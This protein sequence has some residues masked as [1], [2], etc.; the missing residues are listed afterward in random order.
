MLINT[1]PTHKPLETQEKENSKRRINH[2]VK[3]LIFKC[4]S[5]LPHKI[6][7]ILYH[8]IQNVK[9]PAHNFLK[10][11]KTLKSMLKVLDKVGFDLNGKKVMELGSGWAP[12]LPYYFLSHF[13]LKSLHTIDINAHYQSKK[14]EALRDFF[15]QR[16]A[17]KGNHFSS[18]DGLV[19]HE[20][21]NYFPN[22]NL[23]QQRLRRNIDFGYSRFVLEHVPPQDILDIHL[24]MVKDMS[25]NSLILHF[26]SPSDHRSYSDNTLSLHDFLQYSDQEW[27]NIQTRFDYHNRLRFPQYIEI[28][29]KAGL[30]IVEQS[31]SLPKDKGELAKFNKLKIH[32]QFSNFTKDELTA[33]SLM[34]LL[35]KK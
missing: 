23:A 7:D 3:T 33:G 21:I 5:K 35:R 2:K 11:K 13:E 10:E 9:S 18:K 16:Q 28:F 30:E 34:F 19:M 31:H 32:K 17:L 14:L 8:R 25:A 22:F 12:T 24:N 4:L 20:K 26:V 15:V 27:S 29:E 1:I 6:G